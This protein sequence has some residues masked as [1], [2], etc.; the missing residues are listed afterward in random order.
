MVEALPT[1]FTLHGSDWEVCSTGSTP[2]RTAIPDVVHYEFLAVR[3]NCDANG[4][5]MSK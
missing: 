5:N 4:V 1:G 3:A 2:A